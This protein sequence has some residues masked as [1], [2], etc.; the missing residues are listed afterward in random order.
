M[1]PCHRRFTEEKSA[2]NLECVCK[3]AVKIHE[4]TCEGDHIQ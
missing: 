4:N 3:P 1:Y 2:G